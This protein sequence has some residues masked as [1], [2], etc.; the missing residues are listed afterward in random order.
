[1]LRIDVVFHELGIGKVS[2]L[3]RWSSCGLNK[4]IFLDFDL[5]RKNLK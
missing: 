5:G 1:M 3:I 2:P 4:Y